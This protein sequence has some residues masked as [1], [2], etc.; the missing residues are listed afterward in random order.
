[1]TQ[2]AP[3]VRRQIVV[4]A[5]IER[6]FAVSGD[7]KPREHS[8]LG[9]PI[10]GTVSEPK[11]GGHIFTAVAPARTRIDLGHRNQGRHGTSWKSVRDGVE[12][13]EGWPL[14]LDRY[15]ALFGEDH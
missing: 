14:R 15:A 6:A 4:R 2:S 1:M 13:D 9:V 12:H 11:V 5:P 3:W 7:V 8:M 10:A